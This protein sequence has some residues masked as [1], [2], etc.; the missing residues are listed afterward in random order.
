MGGMDM[1]MAFWQKRFVDKCRIKPVSVLKIP[2]H[3]GHF[4]V[5]LFVVMIVTH[6]QHQKWSSTPVPAVHLP[7]G[8]GV[9]LPAAMAKVVKK[10]VTFL[11]KC[12]MQSHTENDCIIGINTVL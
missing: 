11:P 6:P 3:P 7:V 12:A 1:P 10:G 9:G 8:P 2:L 5:K 4:M